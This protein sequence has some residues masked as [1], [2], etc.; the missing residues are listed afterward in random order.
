MPLAMLAGPL[1]K[2]IGIA[3]L[4]AAI[5]GAGYYR[6]WHQE[7]QA[8]DAAIAEQATRSAETVIKQAENTATIETK[9]IKV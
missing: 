1:G 6:G 9:Y 8:W 5:S 3:L 7:K 4:V 2:I